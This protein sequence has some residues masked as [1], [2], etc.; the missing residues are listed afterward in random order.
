MSATPVTPGTWTKMNGLALAGFIVSLV[1]LVLFFFGWI[2]ALIGLVGLIL[3]IIGRRQIAARGERG[4][5][6]ATAGI[7]IGAV[8][9]VLGIVYTVVLLAVIVPQLQQLQQNQ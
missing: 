3:S 7:I 8:A 2:G 4:R 9:V 6:L 5:G 1:G